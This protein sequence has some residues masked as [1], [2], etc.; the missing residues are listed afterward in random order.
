GLAQEP[1]RVAAI[2][3]AIVQQMR[4]WIGAIGETRL[5][6]DIH[7]A[8]CDPGVVSPDIF[9]SVIAPA[10][11]EL[12]A[13]ARQATQRA[14]S[15]FIDGDT[16][17]IAAVMAGT[18]AG[19]VNCPDTT[20]QTGFLARIRSFTEVTVRVELP[21]GIWTGGDWPAVCREIASRAGVARL[22]ARTVLGAGPLPLRAS[23]VLVVDACHFATNMDPW[24]EPA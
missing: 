12:A 6:I 5:S 22:H 1:E 17:S 19:Y 7:E 24:L 3:R 11:A 4:P 18:G 10:V 23:S 9:E 14:P 15:L 16:A 8:A 20:A 2:L 21:R 13:L